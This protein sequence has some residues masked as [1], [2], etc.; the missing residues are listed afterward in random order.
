MKFCHPKAM[1]HEDIVKKILSVPG[2]EFYQM[3]KNWEELKREWRKGDVDE[4]H[5][6]QVKFWATVA[7]IQELENPTEPT[8]I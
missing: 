4:I 5:K 8:A 3:Q 7:A 1:K 2:T 6:Q